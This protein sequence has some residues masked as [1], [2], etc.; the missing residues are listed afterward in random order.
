MP[1]SPLCLMFRTC[2]GF[3]S[4]LGRA[5]ADMDSISELED[6]MDSLRDSLTEKKMAVIAE[7]DV[8]FLFLSR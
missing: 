4:P 7:L 1:P 3:F 6:S 8:C 2:C 5:L